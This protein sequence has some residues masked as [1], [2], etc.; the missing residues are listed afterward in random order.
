LS[1]NEKRGAYRHDNARATGKRIM[2]LPER[3]EGG[4]MIEDMGKGWKRG[5]THERWVRRDGVA[6]LTI[7]RIS[8]TL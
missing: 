4:I 2:S 8:D 7:R 5:T 1:R 6:R 3:T